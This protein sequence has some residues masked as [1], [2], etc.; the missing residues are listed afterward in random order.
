MRVKYQ[1]AIIK[2][3]KNYFFALCLAACWGTAY[4]FSK[5]ILDVI[6]PC[7]ATFLIV[8][9]G[10]LF[11]I[12][13]FGVQKCKLSCPI[14]ELWRPWI[15]SFLLIL[16]PFTAR[17]WGLQYTDPTIAGILNGTVPIWSFLL[18]AVLLKGIDRFTWP[19]AIGVML[20][21]I[22]LLV[23]VTPQLKDLK[24]SA[25]HILALFGYAALLIMAIS[26]ALGNV[27]TKK[28]M[29]DSSAM[30]WQANTVHQYLFAAVILA[31]ISFTVEPMPVWSAF[32][33]KLVM[34]ILCAGVLS[35]AVA[36]LLM[37]ALIRN[38]GATRMASVTY[39]TPVIAMFTD[40]V[41]RGRAP[42]NAEIAGLVII[43]L[44]LLLMQKKVSD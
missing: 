22:G 26:Y 41:F 37:V 13:F 20:G 42:Q 35:S 14:R 8:L 5:N 25:V 6:T 3:M 12:V 28:I 7:W 44:S 40:I 39:F 18:A 29:V 16:L 1:I 17:S 15:I 21:L 11:F 9:A 2:N 19:R 4:L 31:I 27:L 30:T 36:F 32:N 43:L 34:S 33:T 10:L 24:T 23:I 38:W